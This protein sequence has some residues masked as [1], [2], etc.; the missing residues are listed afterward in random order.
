M[1]RLL[2]LTLAVALAS[3]E[4]HGAKDRDA[5]CRKLAEQIRKIEARMRQ[6]Y[7]AAEGVRL[8]ARLRELKRKRY[9][10]CR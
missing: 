4:A 6:P 1:A 8:D 9:R 3:G 2:T 7:T 5:D 10:R